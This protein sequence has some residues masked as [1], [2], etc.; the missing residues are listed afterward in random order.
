MSAA[1]DPIFRS[2]LKSTAALMV[3]L[4]VALAL[5]VIPLG[6]IPATAVAAVRTLAVLVAIVSLTLT[7]AGLVVLRRHARDSRGEVDLFLALNRSREPAAIRAAP[8][9]RRSRLR[10]WT[11][12]RLLGH[13][14]VVGDV[15]EVRSWDE[16]RATLDGRGTLDE[17]PFM[18]EMLPMC[19]RRARVFRCMHRVF[20]YR[21]SRRMRH[22]RGAVLLVGS[23]CDGSRHGG[24]EA[25]C[26]TVWKADWLRRID[27]RAADAR[28][29]DGP[30]PSGA[31]VGAELLDEGTRAPRY[32]CQLTQLHAA[33]VPVGEW[34]AVN[35]LRPLVSGNVKVTAFVVGWL[36]HLFNELQQWRHGVGFPGFANPVPVDGREADG[37]LAPGDA[38]VVRSS[39]EIRATLDDTLEHRGMGFESDMLK[40]CGHRCRVEKEVRRLIDIVTGDMRVLRTRAYILHG[41]HFSGER[42]QFNS[43]YEPLLWRGVW[44]KRDQDGEPG[45]G[46]GP[47]RAG[48]GRVPV[49]GEGAES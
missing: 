46:G 5:A 4:A 12:R 9:V 39:G 41:I 17:L 28:A 13:D 34:S 1:P 19:G 33:S 2:Y 31:P 15:V 32:A 30:V 10:R 24:C 26:H 18:P 14:L 35:F 21:K 47:G 3:P 48:A 38:V 25:A 6:E 29:P 44:L 22:M 20:D 40:Y 11:A 42:Q 36:T 37:P 7:A 16:I 27:P 8:P 43:Q 49:P 23:V 45:P